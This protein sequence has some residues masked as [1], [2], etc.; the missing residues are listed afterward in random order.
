MLFQ[1]PSFVFI[2][3]GA[4]GAQVDGRLDLATENAKQLDR[5]AHGF[6][7]PRSLELSFS[8]QTGFPLQPLWS[9]RVV[10][11][12]V[13][14]SVTSTLSPPASRCLSRSMLGAGMVLYSMVDFES[15]EIKHRSEESPTCHVRMRARTER[16][17]KP[18]KPSE[19]RMP[20]KATSGNG[21]SPTI[22]TFT[23][24]CKI[25]GRRMIIVFDGL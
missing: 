15:R 1:S 17:C 18:F 5:I 16:S 7:S 12:S 4:I 8:L 23:V 13:P 24:L 14:V 3:L 6:G 11:S 9:L 25:S 22:K 2:A 19:S 20:K 10:S 21:A